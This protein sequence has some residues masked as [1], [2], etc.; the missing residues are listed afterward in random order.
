MLIVR[1]VHKYINY[2]V[3]AMIVPLL[4]TAGAVWVESR[5]MHALQQEQGQT[6]AKLRYEMEAAW[7]DS[8]AVYIKAIA[9]LCGRQA[10]NQAAMLQDFYTLL[11]A[12]TGITAL[13]YAGIDGRIQVAT[14]EPPGRYIGNHEYFTV[15]ATG[16]QYTGKIPVLE[17][18]LG[19]AVPVVAVPVTI[20]SEIA[21]I[22]YGVIS[23]APMQAITTKAIAG[24]Q[25]SELLFHRWL[26]WLGAVCLAGLIPP[27]LMGISRAGQRETSLGPDPDQP[28]FPDLGDTLSAAVIDKTLAAAVKMPAA[29]KT[30]AS[31]ETPAVRPPVITAAISSPARSIHVTG[32]DGLAGLVTTAGFD[33]IPATG[34]GVMN[35]GVIVCHVDCV[36]LIHDVLGVQAGEAVINAAAEAILSA[37]G[38]QQTM[39]RLPGNNFAAL[40]TEASPAV[41]T[42]YKKDIQFYVDLHNLH[43]PGLPLSITVGYASAGAGDDRLAV[44]V[45]ASAA[46][47][48]CKAERRLEARNFI[49]WSIKRYHRPD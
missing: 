24:G 49:L 39:T 44:W 1:S 27:L 29:G 33:Q 32:R 48:N 3:L 21:G 46:M 30:A 10:G 13:A 16:Q 40:I 41:L 19:E 17:W 23:E 15:A 7:L 9:G 25:E 2:W 28:D 22:V 26:I 5:H 37:V 47:E 8:Q 20:D 45:K 31:S 36:G 38:L 18:G 11:D 43:Q 42:E 12:N 34:A 35:Q 6:A 14:A 4:L